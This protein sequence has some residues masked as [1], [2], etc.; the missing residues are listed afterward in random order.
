MDLTLSSDQEQLLGSIVDC[1]DGELPLSRLHCAEP[2]RDQAELRR[3]RVLGE[4]GWYR[5]SLPEELGGAGLGFAEEALLFREL[6][7]R[8]AP[9]S[10]LAAVLGGRLAAKAGALDIAEAILTGAPALSIAV[11]ESPIE[12]ADGRLS[13]SVRTFSTGPAELAVL[14]TAKTAVL[15]DLSQVSSNSR[16]C[17]DRTLTMA[18]ADLAGAQVVAQS[19]GDALGT[20]AQLLLA[21]TLTGQAEATRDMITEYAKVRETFGRPIGAYQAVRHPI[22]EMAARCE[23]AKCLLLYAALSSDEGRPD[24]AVQA[25]AARAIAQVAAAKNDDANIQ[26]HGGIGVTDDL[27]AH[28]Y[29]KR[30]VACA[31]W[32]GGAKSHLRMLVD[33]PLLEV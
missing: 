17:L 6:G 9:V 8:L 2:M 33:A 3:L 10:T 5:I 4:L 15:L 26:L 27:H 12:I 30:A 18:R 7:R 22:A 16:P 23:Q 25:V 24:A 29:M 28:L 32:F 1:L 13:G 11:P 20:Q 21:A 31:T 14:A 19:N